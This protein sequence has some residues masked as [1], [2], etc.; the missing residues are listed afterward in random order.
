MKMTHAAREEEQT[1]V[2]G[3]KALAPAVPGVSVVAC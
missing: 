3:V 1:G 2:N